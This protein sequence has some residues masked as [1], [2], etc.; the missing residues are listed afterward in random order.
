[1]NRKFTTWHTGIVC[2]LYAFVKNIMETLHPA[3]RTSCT[4]LTSRTFIPSSSPGRR[5]GD[6]R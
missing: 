3:S 1:M 5:R 4:F 6:S 2:I